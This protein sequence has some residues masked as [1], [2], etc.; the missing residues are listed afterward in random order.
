MGTNIHSHN[1]CQ[2]FKVVTFNQNNHCLTRII[3]SYT[4]I[5]LLGNWQFGCKVVILAYISHRISIKYIHWC[6]I[7]S[8]TCGRVMYSALGC[9]FI[10]WLI[11]WWEA[12]PPPDDIIW[13]IF[14]LPW[15]RIYMWKKF[16]TNVELWIYR[17]PI[18]WQVCGWEWRWGWRGWRA[19]GIRSETMGSTKGIG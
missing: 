6:R 16:Q 17:N 10:C 8:P 15:S 9:A 5:I 11:C 18:W 1:L 14:S 3:G 2:W 7:W 13:R 4:I 12:P 19:C